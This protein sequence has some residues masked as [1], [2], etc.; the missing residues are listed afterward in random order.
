M[1]IHAG[2]GQSVDTPTKTLHGFG[3]VTS[4]PSMAINGRSLAI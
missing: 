2:V 3:S 4:K 1:A